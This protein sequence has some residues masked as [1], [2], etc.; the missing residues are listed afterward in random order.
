MCGEGVQGRS[1]MEGCQSGALGVQLMAIAPC[2]NLWFTSIFPAP[3][4]PW[5][6]EKHFPGWL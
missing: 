6:W 2:L 4:S 1:L 3:A 5:G